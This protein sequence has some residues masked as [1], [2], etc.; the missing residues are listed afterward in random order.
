[1]IRWKQNQELNEMLFWIKKFQ[2]N[3]FKPSHDEKEKDPEKS[4]NAKDEMKQGMDD[5][6]D[7]A[8]AL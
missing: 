8:I 5:E 3:K 2:M 1:M 4:F 7:M 6:T